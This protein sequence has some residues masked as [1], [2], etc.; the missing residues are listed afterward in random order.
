MTLLTVKEAAARLSMSE[1]SLRRAIN[2]GA[3]KAVVRRGYERGI[4]I[5]ESDLE[6]YVE[7][8]W[9]EVES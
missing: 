7:N 1:W 8:Q 4:R 3:L 2:S 5:K 9:V 6:E